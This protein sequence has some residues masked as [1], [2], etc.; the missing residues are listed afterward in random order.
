MTKEILTEGRDIS[1]QLTK[2]R[3]LTQPYFLPYTSNNGWQFI[4]LLF[5]LIFCVVPGLVLFVVTALINI[6]SSGTPDLTKEYL[7]GVQEIINKIW[8]SN[9]GL[10]G[11]ILFLFGISSFVSFRSQLRQKRWVP[12]LFLGLVL[13][14]LL[15]VNGINAG[16]S[17][18]VRD[19][20]NGLINQNANESYR[21]LWIL[22]I[23]FIAALPIRS[24]QF[25]L[26][27]KLQLLWREWLS[28]N[29]IDNYLTDRTYYILNPNDEDDTDIDNPDQRITEDAKDFTAQILD[30]SLN[31]FDSILTFTINI[32][33]LLSISKNLTI[34][35]VIYAGILSILIIF[36]SKKLFKLNFDQLKYEANFRYGLVHVRNNAESIAF[37]SGEDEEYQEVN[38]RLKTVVKNFNLLIIWEALLRVLQRST[39][40]GSVFIPFI[41]LS[42]PLLAG[43]MN[44]GEFS[45]ARLNYQLL[46]GSLFFIIYK[47]EALARFSAS[48]GR[49]EGFQSSIKEVKKLK[50]SQFKN[51][52]KENETIYIKNVNVETPDKRKL[53][54]KDLNLS[55]ESGESV[56]VVGPSGCGKTSLLR[57]ISGLWAIDQ[58]EIF[59]PQKG[60][61]LFIPQKPYMTLG[62]L[63][64]QLC[65]PLRTSR[66]SDDHLQAVL[67]EVQLPN[68]IERYPDL[69]IKQ[70][71]ERI[72]SQGEQQRL[73][74]ARLLLNSPKFVILDEATSALDLK[75][76]H[77]LYNLLKE[78][79]IAL[80][81]V[82]HRPTLQSFHDNVL[83]LSGK[84]NWSLIPSTNFDFNSNIYS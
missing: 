67:K 45:Q 40:Y 61:L 31:I 70:D 8:N 80:V 60:D 39:I 30:L 42:G 12:W 47:I 35:L 38:S 18:L 57:V 36:A 29:L 59:S 50:S 55:V 52:V 71:W 68:L 3:K 33:I 27:A 25:Y 41:I 51:T 74:F 76:E 56:L 34:A 26:S 83:Q 19:I 15:S 64:E 7:S 24:L 10:I 21:K 84:G 32:G 77:Y 82:G 13:L 49:L 54:V 79:N 20:T 9:L 72:L 53:L 14:M 4:L 2:I 22:G 69:D 62:S 81:S 65:Y 73:A 23:C 16:I 58:G 75:T 11:T 46:E 1:S 63:R 48:I 43:N 44:Y 78:R 37:Y 28:N 6:L 66:F 17:F 5:A